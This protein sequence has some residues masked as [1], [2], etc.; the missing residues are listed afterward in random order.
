MKKWIVYTILL[1]SFT[2]I[3]GIFWYQEFIYSL[4]TP[5]PNEYIQVNVGDRIH[6]DENLKT[7]S[8]PQFI[9][10]F[11]PDCPCSKFNI[12]HFK[13]L[14]KKYDDHLDFSVVVLTKDEKHT[15]ESIREKFDLPIQVSFDQE[16]AKSC[17][18]YSTP[19]AAIVADGKLYYRGN[20]NK[21]RYCTEKNSNYAEM[22]IDSLMNKTSDPDFNS[23]ALVSYGCSLPTCKQ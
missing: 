2:S 17:G 13:S 8:K 20:Y 1:T 10:F 23:Y 15:S 5:V 7:S 19:Q 14:V 3:G 9:H 4:P 16:I 18:V 6:L 11:N 21:S 12:S 22:A